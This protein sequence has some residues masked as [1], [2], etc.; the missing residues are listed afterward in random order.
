[1]HE[2]KYSN[3]IVD[4]NGGEFEFFYEGLEET[5][6]LHTKTNKLLDNFLYLLDDHSDIYKDIEFL[7]T[8]LKE[9]EEKKLVVIYE[10][11][12]MREVIKYD[13]SVLTWA[14]KVYKNSDKEISFN[15]EKGF[16]YNKS[17]I[18]DFKNV[19]SEVTVFLDRLT[20]LCDIKP[21][22]INH[23]E[24]VLISVYRAFYK[25]NP[26]FTAEN[27]NLRIQTMMSILSAY[28]ITICDYDSS[29]DFREKE[30]PE[31]LHLLITVN[32]LFPYGEICD[33]KIKLDDKNKR[34]I[35]SV[36]ESIRNSVEDE[37]ELDNTLVNI[38]KTIHSLRYNICS[39]VDVDRMSECL[40]C[41]REEAEKNKELI[42]IINERIEK[43][44]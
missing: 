14:H 15:I 31:S 27:I 20:K 35:E 17:K 4:K 29:S 24:S 22:Q 21:R 44:N 10:N 37:S 28:N 19:A 1:M 7:R 5:N 23:E 9:Y 41:P 13:N 34:I 33:E 12:D 32:S 18:S 40:N 8:I 25:E 2:I 39:D 6:K 30:Y 38:S 16:E 3:R 11:A 36:G 26:D 42:K 43:E